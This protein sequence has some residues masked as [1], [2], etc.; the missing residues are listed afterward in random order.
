ME[1]RGSQGLHFS[2]R[3]AKP[4]LVGLNGPLKKLRDPARILYSNPNFAS[5]SRAVYA[6]EALRF[7]GDH[8]HVRMLHHLL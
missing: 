6:C 1:S 7:G 8:D 5:F 2:C 3:L 4:F